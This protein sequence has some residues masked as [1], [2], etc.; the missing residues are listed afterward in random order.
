M[1]NDVYLTPIEENL[2]EDIFISISEKK[3]RNEMVYYINSLDNS[4]GRAIG[5]D[6]QGQGF[7][8]PMD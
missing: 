3:T 4:D 7:N 8:T 1:T 2:L 6:T 5:Y